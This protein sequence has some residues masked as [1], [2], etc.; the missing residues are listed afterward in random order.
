VQE[1]DSD[2]A[3]PEEV[4]RY[5]AEINVDAMQGFAPGAPIGATRANVELWLAKGSM[6]PTRIEINLAGDDPVTALVE[7]S[8]YGRE[9]VQPARPADATVARDFELPAADCAGDTFVACLEAQS[10]VT[11]TQPCEGAGRR[12]C[13]VPLGRVSP[14][15]IE[16]L[17]T[18]Y[19][20]Q[21]SLDVRVMKPAAIPEQY[22]DP[23][24]DQIDAHAIIE[25]YLGS[26]APDAFFD[27]QAT[28]IAVTA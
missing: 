8:E 25:Y 5:T 2:E 23:L 9:F 20:E 11:G 15:L 17:A 3:S 13:I 6:L 18:H 1:Q 14:A 19:R 4:V 21:Y 22:A 24:R 16:H 10:G 28:M 12:I 26:L 27:L 7:F